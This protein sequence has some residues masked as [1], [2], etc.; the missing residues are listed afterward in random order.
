M[1]EAILSKAKWYVAFGIR[2]NVPNVGALL[3]NYLSDVSQGIKVEH[4]LHAHCHQR[5]HFEWPIHEQRALT[6][7]CRELQRREQHASFPRTCKFKRRE[8][9]VISLSYEMCEASIDEAKVG[10]ANLFSRGFQWS[11][12][13]SVAPPCGLI[14]QTV[15]TSTRN[16]AQNFSF[17]FLAWFSNLYPLRPWGHFLPGLL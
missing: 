1:H 13:I 15:F 11:S 16:A 9:S 10:F 14:V 7:W 6:A 3:P 17:F 8:F 12:A 4:M 2:L 5:Q